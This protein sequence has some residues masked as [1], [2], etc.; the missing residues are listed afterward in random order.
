MVVNSKRALF[1]RPLARDDLVELE[2]TLVLKLVE[3][4]EDAVYLRHVAEIAAQVAGGDVVCF[5]LPGAVWEDRDV[6]HREGLLT[7]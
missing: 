2:E 6:F 7:R 5:I 1:R 4:R 3:I